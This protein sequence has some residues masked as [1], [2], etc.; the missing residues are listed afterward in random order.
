VTPEEFDGFYVGCHQRLVGQL[1]AMT[2]DLAEAEDVVQEAFVPAWDRR[3]QLAQAD[4]P[5]AWVRTVAW[6]L[7][8]SRWRRAR[9]ALRTMR[10]HG[11]PSIG[12]PPNPDHVALISALR[13][14]PAE[15]RRAIVRTTCATCPSSRW[16]TRPAPRSAPSRPGCP[17]AAPR[18]PST[19]TTASRRRQ[20]CEPLVGERIT[21][22][23]EARST[24]IGTSSADRGLRQ[25]PARRS[26]D[27]PTPSQ[28][29]LRGLTDGRHGDPPRRWASEGGL[30]VRRRTA[31][32]HS[33]QLPGVRS[34]PSCGHYVASI[35]QR[36]REV[37]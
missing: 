1:F 35:E 15:Q 2:G 12:E 36:I 27:C 33:R 14:L 8:I 3:K 23:N 20:A 29:R 22:A 31:A 28:G 26:R 18:S 19:S 4:S 11:T 21:D 34:W 25:V 37:E 9:T 7:A 32:R 16:R 10:R 5:K 13:R 6:R 24:P 30:S 17:A